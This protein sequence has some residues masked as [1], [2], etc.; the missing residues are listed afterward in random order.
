MLYDV[1][2]IPIVPIPAS[3]PSF[4]QFPLM[5]LWGILYDQ[6]TEEKKTQSQFTDGSA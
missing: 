1:A 4:S 2:Q 6:L 3:V 5:A